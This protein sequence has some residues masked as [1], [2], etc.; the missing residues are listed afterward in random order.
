M[1]TEAPTQ[2]PRPEL[3]ASRV[4]NDSGPV[5]LL[6][7]ISGPREPGFAVVIQRSVFEAIHSHGR[8]DTSVE[9]C[10]VLVGNICHDRIS[11]YLLI[12]AHIPG[13]K[14]ASKE[15]QVTFTAE[16]WDTIQKAMEADHPDK[17]VVGWYHTHPGFG[18]FLSGM[19][20]FIQDNFF[21]LPWQVAWVY[22]PVAETDGVFVWRAGKSEKAEY[23][24][25][26]NL[27]EWGTDFRAKL[28]DEKAPAKTD[29][30]PEFQ[31]NPRDWRA[32]PFRQMAMTF[33]VFAIFFSFTWLAMQWLTSHGFRFRLPIDW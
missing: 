1:S 7:R 30:K 5:R 15:T 32:M 24:I 19:D 8:T 6:R 20:L 17:K 28:R 12:E 25:E 14:A 21:N 33:I 10:G 26:E 3:D 2:P 11:P 22:D 27:G 4:E 31:W 23:L 16:T 13:D 29:F 18:I 9:I